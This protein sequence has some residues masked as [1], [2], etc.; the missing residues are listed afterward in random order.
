MY[1]FKLFLPLQSSFEIDAS[2]KAFAISKLIIRIP[3]IAFAPW[4]GAVLL[5]KRKR[6]SL[7]HGWLDVFR[8]DSYLPVRREATWQLAY[9]V[10]FRLEALEEKFL[11]NLNCA[12]GEREVA[13]D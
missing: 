11:I 1:L 3:F 6:Y 9:T 7:N 12:G 4:S 10:S 5:K 13:N 2:K 8:E